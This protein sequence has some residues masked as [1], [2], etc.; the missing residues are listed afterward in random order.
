[1]PL[2]F[3]IMMLYYRYCYYQGAKRVMGGTTAVACAVVFNIFGIFIIRN[4]RRLDDEQAD[5]ALME[6]YRP[7][8]R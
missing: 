1:M 2:G 7:T 6:K 8:L 5:A 3:L 4:S